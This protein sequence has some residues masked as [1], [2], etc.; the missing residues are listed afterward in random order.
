MTTQTTSLSRVEKIENFEG[1]RPTRDLYVYLP[2]GYDESEQHY[3]VIYMHDGQNCFNAFIGD[4]FSHST[5]QA[6]L[7][8]DRLIAEQRMAACIIVG[9]SH[10]GRLRMREYRPEYVTY[11]YP[12]PHVMKSVS[13]KGEASKSRPVAGL[14]DEMAS[15][16]RHDVAGHINENYRTLTGPENTAT[17]GSSLGGLFS[18]YLA[19][20]HSGFAKHHAALSPSYWVTR[21]HNSTLEVI[22]RIYNQGKIPIRFWLDSGTE[23]VPGIGDDGMY[24]AICAKNVIANVGFTLGEDFRYK[25]YE[26][27]IHNEDAWA[28][29]LDGVFSFLFPY[30]SPE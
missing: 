23:A 9:V 4:S 2:A 13:R 16:Y 21:K 24:D 14:A 17:C 12:S 3:P 7:V 1:S 15:Y 10:G 6:D 11:Q 19:W 28:A 27:A 25:I 26:N 20:E 18:T 8:A 30:Q 5:W 29:R 22:N